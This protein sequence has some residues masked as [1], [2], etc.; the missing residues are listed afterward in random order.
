MRIG[1]VMAVVGGAALS[2][3]AAGTVHVMLVPRGSAM[4]FGGS[5]TWDIYANY[6]QVASSLSIAEFRFDI[7]G[8]DKGYFTGEVY[9]AKFPVGA[10]D[11]TTGVTLTGFA[12]GQ[13]APSMG[14]S[15]T[16]NYL[17][18]FTYHDV[19]TIIPATVQ[20][21]LTNFVGPDGALS[22]YTSGS[23]AKS[24]A[25]LTSDTGGFHTV[26]IESIPVDFYLFPTPGTAMAMLMGVG[27]A[28]RRRR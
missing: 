9:D 2:A 11:G 20:P 26:V 13:A 5:M 7:G 25:S 22:V 10:S 14:G 4:F 18:S 28:T 15:Y 27:L 6:S 17:G 23:G 3:A 19:S 8:Y 24:V 1:C 12:G 21:T 16:G